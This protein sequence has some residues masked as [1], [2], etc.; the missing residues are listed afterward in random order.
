MSQQDALTTSLY[1]QI[2]E[3]AVANECVALCPGMQGSFVKESRRD[4]F[5]WY[6]VGRNNN[7]HVGR[8][9]IG[10]DNQHTEDLIVRVA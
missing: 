1:S 4:T 6:W 8:V 10:T 7:G 9:Y 3:N 5:Y 2:F